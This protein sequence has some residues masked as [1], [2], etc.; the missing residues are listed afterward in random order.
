MQ[1]R[2][3][4]PVREFQAFN[5]CPKCDKFGIF[6]M[7]QPPEL[8]TVWEDSDGD[9]EEIKSWGGETVVTIRSKPRGYKTDKST[10]DVVRTCHY[11]NAQWGEK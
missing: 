4:I 5:N 6:R 3:T 8:D 9:F 11:C 2:I 10:C 7:E 1:R